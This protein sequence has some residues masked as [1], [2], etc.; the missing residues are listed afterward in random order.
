MAFFLLTDCFPGKG[1]VLASAEYIVNQKVGVAPRHLLLVGW[2][3][4]SAYWT[5]LSEEKINGHLENAI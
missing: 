1:C 5:R 2:H 3:I 4:L